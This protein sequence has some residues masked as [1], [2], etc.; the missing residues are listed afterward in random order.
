MGHQ[1]QYYCCPND[2]AEIDAEVFRPSQGQLFC[3]EKRSER[4]QLEKVDSFAL[5]LEKMGTQTLFLLLAPPDQLS[6]VVFDGPWVDIANS[7]LVEVGRC[8]IKDGKIRSGRF[9][10]SATLSIKGKRI[11]KPKEFLDWSERIFRQ[12][13]SKLVRQNVKFAGKQYREWFGHQAW[14]DVSGGK[15]E[16]LAN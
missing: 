7:H 8:Y 1:F 4:H 16:P 11:D 9:W 14:N 13:K 3:A 10:Y 5:S 2:L 6:N 12:A 15:L